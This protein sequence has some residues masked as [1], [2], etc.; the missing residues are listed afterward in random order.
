MGLSGFDSRLILFRRSC[1]PEIKIPDKAQLRRISFGELMQREDEL[2][3]AKPIS[4]EI[5]VITET[6]NGYAGRWRH[7]KFLVSAE[8][9]D[10]QWW[11]HTSVSRRDRTMPRYEDLKKC[12]ELTIGDDR[13]AIQVFATTEEHI[14]HSERLGIEVL[15]LWSPDFPGVLPNFR[16]LGTI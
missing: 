8:L 2:H 13:M 14:D 16:L 11:I 4:N 3:K 5:R 9:H 6:V 1:K 10:G 15:H 7:L 12:K